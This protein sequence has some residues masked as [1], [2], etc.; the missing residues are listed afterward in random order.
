MGMGL[1]R[2]G[3]AARAAGTIS[4]RLSSITTLPGWSD[5]TV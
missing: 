1:N 4:G 2:V 5:S 3:E